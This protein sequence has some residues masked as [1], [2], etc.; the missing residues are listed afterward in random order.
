[1]PVPWG[2]QLLLCK[3]SSI[4]VWSGGTVNDT[5]FPYN[6][7]TVIQRGVIG[8]AAIA[9]HE[10]G[11]GAALIFVGDDCAVHA[12]AGGYEPV[13]ISP[14]ALER[15]I[16]AVEDKSTLEASVYIADGHPRWVLSCA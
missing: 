1:R 14:P 10:D 11:F 9:G 5:G 4:E 16:E 13:R 3:S 15:L 2:D 6:R 12:L 8:A 7:V